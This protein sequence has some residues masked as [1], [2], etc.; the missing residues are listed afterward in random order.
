MKSQRIA[1]L[2]L[3]AILLLSACGASDGD[4]GASASKPP[5]DP[6]VL[7]VIGSYSG[8]Q[9]ASIGLADEGT[10]VWADA[11]NDSGGINGHPVE[12]VIKDD[13]GDPAK[14]LQ[15]VKELV[16][17]EKVMAIIANNSLVS[18]SWA[19]YVTE[20]GV[21]V[22]GGNPTESV[23]FSNPNFYPIGSNV[24]T[25][26]FGQFEQMKKA[27]LQKM[28]LLYCAESPTCASLEGLA[29]GLA[30]V[31]GDV[32]VVA[33]SKVSAT[34]PLYSAECLAMK[35]AGADALFVGHNAAA[36]VAITGGCAKAG[37][38]PVDV[39][40]ATVVSSQTLTAP[41][42]NGTLLTG[43]DVTQTDTSVPGNKE[44]E[45]AI[46]KFQPDM[47]D[48]PQY[49]P[50]V[51][52][53]WLSG[54]M[55]EKVAELANLGPTSTSADV[56]KGIYMIKDET[57]GGVAPPLTYT[58][59]QPTFLDC[60]FNMTIEDGKMVMDGLDPQCLTPD[61]LEGI[62]TALGGGS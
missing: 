39:N 55:F 45:D 51:Q 52:W 31:A 56:K 16:E 6:I 22:I 38:D 25:M 61:Q 48:D 3:G 1:A 50:N 58:E 18:S 43:P 47:I 24:V 11:V 9:A 17:E 37:Y 57:L 27:G 15:S 14:S 13:A 40:Q 49:T 34:Q 42:L 5:G 36:V 30:G 29:G 41:Q 7:G 46:K 33:A 35:D 4:S 44:M 32:E 53:A 23:F 26:I 2:A 21:P 62:T 54:K 20:K 10:Q 19:D 8:S 59:G 60:W 28:G 12:L